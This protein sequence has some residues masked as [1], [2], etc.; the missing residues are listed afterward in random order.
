MSAD[1]KDIESLSSIPP[2]KTNS[3]PTKQE[4]KADS[5]NKANANAKSKYSPSLLYILAALA[6][7]NLIWGAVVTGLY[8]RECAKVESLETASTTIRTDGTLGIA[9]I[10]HINVVVDDDVEKGAKYYE[11]T[12]GFLPA[13]NVDGP[14]LY[15]NITNHGFCVD[16]GFETCRVDIVFLKH[17]IMNLYLEL[18]FYYE[19]DTGNQKIPILQTND[20]GGIRHIAVE[21]SDA[22]DTYNTLKAKDHQGRFI[23]KES[24]IPLDPF[25]YT[26]FY[27]VDRYGVQW[28]F[29][30]GRPVEYGH[31]A[32]ITG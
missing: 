1:P 9:A 20:V 24:P 16:A 30:Q 11:D 29:E 25:P 19:P 18:F 17:E 32:G 27:W 4:A 6:I 7:I 3:L 13:S 23:T 14:M 26:F 12:L 31:V 28:E 8:V 10:S 5:D 15:T 21:V 22:V 2:A